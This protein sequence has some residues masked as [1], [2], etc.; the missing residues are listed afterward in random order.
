LTAGPADFADEP[1]DRHSQMNCLA[2]EAARLCDLAK[3]KDIHPMAL[4]DFHFVSH[5][6]ILADV[7]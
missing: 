3:T 4:A 7:T 2:H 1:G 6:N 5:L